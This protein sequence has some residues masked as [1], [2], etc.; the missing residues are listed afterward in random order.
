MIRLVHCRLPTGH[1]AIA[2]ATLLAGACTGDLNRGIEPQGE[3]LP[4]LQ[5]RAG[6]SSS[7]PLATVPGEWR[8]VPVD[9]GTWP[10]LVLE[11]PDGQVEVNP[12]SLWSV[13]VMPGRPVPAGAM[14]TAESATEVVGDGGPLLADAVADPFRSAAALV[15]SPIGLVIRPPWAIER[16]PRTTFELRRSSPPSPD[17]PR[18]LPREP[19]PATEPGP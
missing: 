7:D 11:V 10:L 3:V 19:P 18:F 5:P 13:A 17:L 2:G 12:T 6:S 15:L 1:L 8:P 14:P 9:R 16:E 4:D